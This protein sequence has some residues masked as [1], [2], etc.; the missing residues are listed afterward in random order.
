MTAL[1]AASSVSAD[2]TATL[3]VTDDAARN[4]ALAVLRREFQAIDLAVGHGRRRLPAFN[5]AGGVP[6]TMR[7]GAGVHHNVNPSTDLPP[8][9]CWRLSA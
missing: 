2:S 9:E 1:F 5:V 4:R 3:V 7:W 8:V 6:V